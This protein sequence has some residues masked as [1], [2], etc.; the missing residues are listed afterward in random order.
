EDR[1]T[2][3]R[4]TCA[5]RLV[6]DRVDTHVASRGDGRDE[7]WQVAVLDVGGHEIAQAIKR[8]LRQFNGT[9]GAH[10]SLRR[11]CREAARRYTPS[12]DR[13]V[14]PSTS[15]R[16]RRVL[17]GVFAEHSR[18]S[19]SLWGEE[20]DADHYS[21]ERAGEVSPD[22]VDHLSRRAVDRR[23]VHACPLFS[24]RVEDDIDALHVT[25]VR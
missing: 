5:D 15:A 11:T 25:K 19:L 18:V 7:S 1:V 2:R 4:A 24:M 22:R 10:R 23:V 21:G 16:E 9:H 6:A 8:P 20:L 17:E 3:H 12:A 14:L 13:D